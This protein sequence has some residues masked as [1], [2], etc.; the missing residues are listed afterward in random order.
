MSDD[1]WGVGCGIEGC[2]VRGE[3]AEAEGKG[4]WLRGEG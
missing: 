4:C 1:A 3:G 2:E